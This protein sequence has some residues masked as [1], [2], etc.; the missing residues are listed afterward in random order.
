M[1]IYDK[2]KKAPEEP[3]QTVFTFDA[4]PESAAEL[5][6]LPEA[7]L[8]TPFRTAA[9]AVCALCAAA[10]DEAIGVEMLNALRG[11]RP[12]S[13]MEIQFLRDRLRG[14]HYVPFS[15]VAGATPEN[16]YTPT[17]PFTLSFKETPYSYQN[18]GYATLYLHSGGADSDRQITLRRKGDGQWCLWEHFGLLPDI[19]KPKSEDPW[20]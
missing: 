5:M 17:Q 11:P 9:L 1:S 15:Y 7:D 20:A 12:L 3:K 13:V 8:S 18:E 19:R 14:K 16:D 2:L 6:A 10:A 4:L